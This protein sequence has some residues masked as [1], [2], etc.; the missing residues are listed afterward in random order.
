MHL[1]VVIPVF[2][3]S[4]KIALDLEVALGFMKKN[5]ISGE[6]IVV[7]DGST[8]RTAD[9]VTRE[10]DRCNENIHLMAMSPSALRSG[11]IRRRSLISVFVVSIV[12]SILSLSRV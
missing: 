3:E 10:I 12:S 5:D 2:N 6:V 9:V 11:K 8:D 1:S 4:G 7:D